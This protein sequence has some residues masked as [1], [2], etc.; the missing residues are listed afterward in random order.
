MANPF[1]ILPLNLFNLFITHGDVSL[2]RHYMAILLRIYTL[3]EFN[4]FGLARECVVAEIM[5]YLRDAGANAED[6]TSEAVLWI[7]VE[8]AN[9]AAG[10]SVIARSVLGDE[11]SPWR[12]GDT[13]FNREGIASQKSLAM[14]H[15]QQAS[16][17]FEG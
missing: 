1:D 10:E 13:I 4:R 2:Q 7:K 6:E 12:R 3:A 11:A 15:N 17:G 9:Q 14:T 16:A 8:M 5:D